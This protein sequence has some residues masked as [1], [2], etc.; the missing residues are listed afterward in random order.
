MPPSNTFSPSGESETLFDGETSVE[1]ELLNKCGE[2]GGL[3][4]PAVPETGS[5]VA[6]SPSISSSDQEASGKFHQE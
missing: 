4:T 3:G 1:D 6:F 2:R 5:N